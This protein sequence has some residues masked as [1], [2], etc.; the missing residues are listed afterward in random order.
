M[1][2]IA[3]LQAT[4]AVEDR[5]QG[6]PIVFAHGFPL[7]HSMWDAQLAGL[8]DSHR[9]IAP[10]LRGF[11]RS[12]VTPGKV[13]MA[14]MADDC[15]AILETLGVDEPVTFVGLSMGGYVAWQFALRHPAKLRRLVVCDSRAV[16]DT[17]QGVETRLKMAEIVLKHGTESVAEAMLPKLFAPTTAEQLPQV[18]DAVRQMIL[19]AAPEGVAAA[20]RGMAERPDVTGELPQLSVPTLILCGTHDA[21][22][23]LAEMRTIAE[24]IPGAKLVEIP[25]AGHMAPMENPTAVNDALRTFL[26]ES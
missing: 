18:V 3:A 16:A 6:S 23:P 5:G 17:P 15:A 26:A 14:D 4:F 11:G 7:D 2:M 9:V 22:S 10:D 25:N 21:I 1:K 12:T 13:T 8:A 20:Q 24:Q 19:H